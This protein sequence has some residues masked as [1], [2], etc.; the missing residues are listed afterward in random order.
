MLLMWGAGPK[1][2]DYYQLHKSYDDLMLLKNYE[3]WKMGYGEGTG[4]TVYKNFMY[5]NFYGTSGMAKVD[6][7]PSTLVLRCPQ[8]GATYNNCFSYAGAPWK[9]IDFAGHEKGL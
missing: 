5:F 3:E 9:D 1:D 7:S 6:L 8:P 2:F 4:N